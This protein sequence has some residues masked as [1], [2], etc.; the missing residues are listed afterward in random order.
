[1]HACSTSAQSFAARSP[2]NLNAAAD[3]D[4]AARRVDL[5]PKFA[6]NP[7]GRPAEGDD[8]E[9][10][11]YDDDDGMYYFNSATEQT[12]YVREDEDGNI[13]YE[14]GDTE[15]VLGEEE[16]PEDAKKAGSHRGVFWV[17]LACY[18]FLGACATGNSAVQCPALR[19]RAK[20]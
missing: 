4:G 16:L 8:G 7:V 17:Y 15:E 10:A 9:W 2:P 11:Y 1:M 18:G 14:D 5:K 6:N 20:R 19:S 3:R 12:V 13:Y